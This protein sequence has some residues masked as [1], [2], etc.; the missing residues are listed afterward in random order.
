MKTQRDRIL[1]Y[2]RDFGTITPYDAFTDLGITKLATRISEL[3]REGYPIAQTRIKSRNRY[4]E[5]THYMAYRL[6]ERPKVEPPE[7]W[8][9][10]PSDEQLANFGYIT[11]GTSNEND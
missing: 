3:K 2:I 10:W 6:D 11:K 7:G 4:G 8:S 9:P 5:P 1:D